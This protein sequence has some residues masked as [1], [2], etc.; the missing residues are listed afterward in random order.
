MWHFRGGFWNLF[1][2]LSWGLLKT[3]CFLGLWVLLDSMLTNS[4]Q[5]EQ[6]GFIQ[7]V[8]VVIGLPLNAQLFGPDFTRHCSCLCKKRDW[9][10]WAG[11]SNNAIIVWAMR[12]SWCSGTFSCLLKPCPLFWALKRQHSSAGSPA[13]IPGLN[14]VGS[15]DTQRS[16]EEKRM[17]HTREEVYGPMVLPEWSRCLS[18]HC[19]CQWTK[20]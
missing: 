1:Y 6:L 9:V 12:R 8:Q 15:K 18:A 19:W 10:W 11:F 13:W 17:Q 2:D 20:M 7:L 3:F 4:T 5:N 14:S 16:S